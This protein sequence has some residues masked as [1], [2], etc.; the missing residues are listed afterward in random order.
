MVWSD[1]PCDETNNELLVGFSLVS[2]IEKENPMRSLLLFLVGH[3]EFR[4]PGL[5][6][7]WRVALQPCRLAYP[8]VRNPPSLQ[9]HTGWPLAAA[10]PAA[11][12]PVQFTCDTLQRHQKCNPAQAGT[13]SHV[14]RAVSRGQT[15]SHS[16]S[17]PLALFQVPLKSPYASK[18]C[19]HHQ[20]AVLER[21]PA[22]I[23]IC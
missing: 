20:C 6:M 14:A 12:L 2:S 1:S 13:S 9:V 16:Y 23:L 8:G 21:P 17:L 7:A 19:T 22:S 5:S 11:W 15:S 4:K 3:I 10:A 18:G